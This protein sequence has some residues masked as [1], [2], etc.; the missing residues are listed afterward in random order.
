MVPELNDDPYL[1]RPRR[2]G[3]PASGFD[4]KNIKSELGRI[5][6]RAR[7]VASSPRAE[8]ADGSAFYDVANMVMVR[9]ASL[10]ER[11][12]FAP[13]AELLTDQEIVS[14]RAMRNIVAHAG[15]VAMDDDLFWEAVTE[16]VPEVVERLLS[17]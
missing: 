14:I 4:E 2:R 8:F 10:T 12:E 13:W 16:L 6:Q 9:F 3:T 7:S 17:K 1:R 15:Y 5:R 11:S